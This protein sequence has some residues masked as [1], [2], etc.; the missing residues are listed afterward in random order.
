MS[1]ITLV[2]LFLTLTHTITSHPT[3]LVIQPTTST[4]VPPSSTASSTTSSSPSTTTETRSTSEIQALEIARFHVTSR[5]QFRYTRT[6]IESYVKNPDIAAQLVDFG[7]I[8]PESAFISNFTMVIDS[9]EYV[10]RVEEKEKAEKTFEEAV[11]RG[12]GAGLVSQDDRDAN[13]F[14]VSANIESGHLDIFRLTYD[15]LLDRVDGMYEQNINVE[16]KEI[17]EDF[18]IEIH[19]NESLPITTINVFSPIFHLPPT[20]VYVRDILQSNEIDSKDEI[21]SSVTEVERNFDGDKNAKIVFAPT[22]EEQEAARKQ[23]EF[24]KFVVRYDVDR[25][26]QDSEIQVIDGYFVHYF[27]PDNLTTL[28]KHVVF[29]L[30]TSGSMYGD[31]IQQLKDSMFTVLN[32]LKPTDFFNI[33]TFSSNVIHWKRSEDDDNVTK[34]S[35]DAVTATKKNTKAAIQYVLDLEA[36]GYTDINLAILAGLEV[37][38]DVKIKETLPQGVA[39]MI[40]FLSDGEAT[41]GE[42]NSDTIKTN[43]VKANFDHQIPIFSVAFG[44]DADFEL[45]KDI[46]QDTDSYAKRV[47]EGSDAALQLENFYTEISSPLVTNLRFNYVGELVDNSSVSDTKTRTFFKGGQFLV[48]GKLQEAED[49]ELE[50]EVTGDINQGTY[51]QTIQI[52]HRN[53][54]EMNSSQFEVSSLFPSHCIL[55]SPPVS[56]RSQ[57]QEFMQSLHAFLNIQQLIKKDKKEAALALSLENNFVTSLTS[58]VVVRPGEKDTLVQTSPTCCDYSNYVSYFSAQPQY[59]GFYGLPGGGG[60]GGA[61]PT[62]GLRL[63]FG[64][65]GYPQHTTT[66]PI[67]RHTTTYPTYR[68]TTM[69]TTTITTITTTTTY[70]HTPTIPATITTATPTTTTT[71]TTTTSSPPTCSSDG[72]L[73]LYN[74]T[75]HRGEEV[76]ILTDSPNLSTFSDQAVSATVKGSCCWLLFSDP[77][78]GGDS[79]K[80][81]PGEEY[82]ITLSFGRKLFQEVSSVRKILC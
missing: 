19:I 28:P 80:L 48:T 31:K 20:D 42:T 23:G 15:Q 13:R 63:R 77:D 52:C 58:L 12:Q 74:S 64:A 62:A 3:N 71:T 79:Y 14:T 22:K 78:Y 38:R 24:G 57:A 27:V 68:H 2:Y 69:T 8:I 70:H 61:F 56:R 54:A 40:V 49:G 17:V 73:T 9:T 37:S 53:Q 33:I 44:R 21:D 36:D 47:Y 16:L 43:I 50:V 60:S 55:P 11:T 67:Y 72:S 34:S 6:V 51:H 5:I 39:S 26:G 35:V 7:V 41:E 65:I 25:Q 32:D 82:K 76:T 29:V 4:S 46:S 66:Y 30:D 81:I 75:Y 1:P 45:L 18:K 10:A 59:Q